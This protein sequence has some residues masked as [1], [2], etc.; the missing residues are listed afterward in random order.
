[1]TIYTPENIDEAPETEYCYKGKLYF[2]DDK[3]RLSN[4][5]EYCDRY[6][7]RIYNAPITKSLFIEKFMTSYIR[8][9]MDIGHPKLMGQAAEDTFEIYVEY[10]LEGNIGQLY[11][12]DDNME[13][14]ELELYWIGQMYAYMH[15]LSRLSGKDIYERLPLAEMRH[16]YITGHEM[17]MYAAFEKLKGALMYYKNEN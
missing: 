6:A 15:C 17:S 16:F 13:Y 3:R 5:L 10:E 9:Q 4:M 1:M 2:S 8:S 11:T 14:G 12:V 7:K